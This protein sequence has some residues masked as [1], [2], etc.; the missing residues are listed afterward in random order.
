MAKNQIILLV[1]VILVSVYLLS[2][3]IKYEVKKKSKTFKNT[4]EFPKENLTKSQDEKPQEK[5]ELVQEKKEQQEIQKLGKTPDISVALLDELHEF[6]N[7]LKERVTPETKNL[8]KNLHP[9]E[10]PRFSA[11]D[12]SFVRNKKDYYYS[13]YDEF[14]DEFDDDFSISDRQKTTRQSSLENLP[15][16]IKILMMTDFFDTKF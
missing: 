9:Y 14:D 7:Y 4:K 5:P 11:L 10:T 6:Q 8:E 12:D 1:A 13:N 16:E 3:L 2:L 15:N